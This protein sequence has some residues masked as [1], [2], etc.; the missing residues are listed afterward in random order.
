VL[1][2]CC[3]IPIA[4]PKAQMKLVRQMNTANP[5][6]SS[7]PWPYWNISFSSNPFDHIGPCCEALWL[8]RSGTFSDPLVMCFDTADLRTWIRIDSA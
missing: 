1:R 6:F 3:W 4:L 2:Q 8:P 7:S 5:S